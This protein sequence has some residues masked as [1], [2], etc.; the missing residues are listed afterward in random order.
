M[1]FKP[2]C[3]WAFIGV[4]T[5]IDEGHF[6]WIFP[7]K[8]VA[9]CRSNLLESFA[10]FSLNLVRLLKMRNTIFLALALLLIGC[11]S[12]SAHYST[13]NEAKANNLFFNRW[14]PD[15]LPTSTVNIETHHNLETNTSEGHFTIPEYDLPKFIYELHPI[16][17]KT[18]TY[19]SSRDAFVWFFSVEDDGL[20]RYRLISNAS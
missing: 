1:S 3:P 2:P 7:R 13:Y 19:G 20:V 14:L 16:T 11:D 15:I 10:P 4:L 12:N 18:Y 8:S 5:R 17:D 9:I 6:S